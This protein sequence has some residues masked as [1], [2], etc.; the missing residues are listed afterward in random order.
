METYVD[1]YINSDGGKA[2]HVFDK[3]TGF[4]LKHHL[5]EH[6]FIYDWKGVVD[7]SEEIQFIDKLQAELRGTGVMLKFTTK[8]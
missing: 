1:V 5:G 6:D 2:S 7:I 8:R 4:G 3:L